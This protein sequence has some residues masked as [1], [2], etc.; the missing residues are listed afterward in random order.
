MSSDSMRAIDEPMQ[1]W[2]PSPNAKC[3]FASRSMR[4]SP[5]SSNAAGSWFAVTQLMSTMSPRLDV[6]TTQLHVAGGGAGEG[7][8]GAV[9]A[10]ELLHCRRDQ[11]RDRR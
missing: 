11:A 6:T 2:P 4:I 3:L 1:R 5:G 9:E 7:L 10:E 8:A